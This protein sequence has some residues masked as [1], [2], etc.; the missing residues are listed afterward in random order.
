MS[1]IRLALLGYFD[2]VRRKCIRI[3]MMEGGINGARRGFSLSGTNIKMRASR[4]SRRN[5]NV[6]VLLRNAE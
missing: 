5:Y 3:K 6:K 1:Q 2:T 4:H